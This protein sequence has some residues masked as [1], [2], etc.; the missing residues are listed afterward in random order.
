MLLNNR[1]RIIRSLGSGGFGETFLAEDTQI[2]S[3]RQCVIKQLKLFQDSPQTYQLV[4][5]RFARE[6]AI[7]EALGD[8]SPQIPRLYAYFNEGQRFYLAQE[9]IQGQTLSETVVSGSLS[10]S[11]VREILISLLKLLE[12]VHSQGIVHRDIKPENIII[13]SSDNQP[14]LIDFGAV[15]ETMTA[16][17]NSQ[18]NVTSSIVIGTPGFMPIEQAAG[19]AVFASD[20]YSLGLVAIYLLTAKLPQELQTDAHNGEI[21]WSKNAVSHNL[22]AVL[23]RAIRSHVKER[24]STAKE[25]LEALQPQPTLQVVPSSRQIAKP[26]K[27]GNW[28]KSILMGS[29]IGGCV[30]LA[31][32]FIQKNQQS[33]QIT[34]EPKPIETPIP[35]NTPPIKPPNSFYFLADSAFRELNNANNQITDLKN[36]GYNQAGKFWL[37]D[38]PNLSNNPYHQ[39]YAA[40]FSSLTNCIESLRSYVQANKNAYCALASQDTNASPN[41]FYGSQIKSPKID[42]K[43]SPSQAVTDY[44]TT[45]NNRNY[46]SSWNQLSPRFQRNKSNNSYSE[47]IDWWNKVQRV[48]VEQAKTVSTSSNT[49]TVEVQMKYYLKS[50]RVI[51][52]AQQFKLVWN[53]TQQNW[54]F[55]DSSKLN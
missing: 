22:A 19:R 28:F 35:V 54:N 9:Y 14:V 3:T 30:L 47:Y 40:K 34:E 49:A 20:L 43:P 21:I 32:V 46:S 29:V 48:A 38:Y 37:Q 6:A 15:R 24:F 45:I 53:A 27:G 1:Y 39:V 8:G 11:R 18:G 13:R 42:S 31:F 44:Y 7:L 41:Y 51:A 4:R 16:Q 36:A 50:G 12:Y 26:T 17:V 10:E 2:P 25:M 33:Q 23:D 52:D 5:Q 55:D